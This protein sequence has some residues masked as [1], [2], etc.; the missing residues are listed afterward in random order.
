MLLLLREKRLRASPLVAR[1]TTARI[2]W[3]F[4]RVAEPLLKTIREMREVKT[5]IGFHFREKH[6]KSEEKLRSLVERRG[7][8][9]E[10]CTVA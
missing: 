8:L 5:R 9:A 10:K 2:L 4:M 7:A 1:S 6:E 3:A